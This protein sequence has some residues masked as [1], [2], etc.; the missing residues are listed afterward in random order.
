MCSSKERIGLPDDAYLLSF[1][2]QD[3]F[4]SDPNRVKWTSARRKDWKK[5]RKV[6]IRCV[7]PNWPDQTVI[8]PASISIDEGTRRPSRLRR[9]RPIVEE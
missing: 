5:A 1:D 2:P 9:R 3:V 4:Q 6:P 7:Y 8:N